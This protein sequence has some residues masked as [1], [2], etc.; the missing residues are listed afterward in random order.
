MIRRALPAALLLLLVGCEGGRAFKSSRTIAEW[1]PS[2]PVTNAAADPEGDSFRATPP[3][4]VAS[5]PR[6]ESLPTEARLSNGIRVV[7][8]ERHDF[9]SIAAV[10]VLDRGATAGAPGVAALYSEAM[11]RSSS[12]YTANEAWQ[13]FQFVGASVANQTWRDGIALQ[14]SALSPLFVSALTRAAPMFT[15][16]AF[17]GDDIDEAR[18]HLAAER[19][20]RDED[21]SD[22]AY[23]AL[24][25]AIF[26]P[27]H[28][29]GTP[30]SGE[31]ARLGARVAGHS[32]D[33]T[34][35]VTNAAVKAFRS[36][37]LSSEHVGV[38][39]VGDFKPDAMRRILE[40]ALG[41]IPKQPGASSSPAASSLAVAPK[42][43]HRVIVIDRPGAAQSNVAIG[44]PGVRSS[45]PDLVTL[46]V[47]AG[48]TAGDLSTRLNLTVRKELGASYGVQ[49]VAAGLRDAGIV[50]IATAID[51]PKT[52]DALRGLFKD[53]ER[54]RAEPLTPGE[55]AAA[56]LRSYANLERGSSRGLAVYLGHAI[57]EGLPPAHAVMH[58]ARVDLVTADGV[59][60][61]AQRYLTPD[62]ARVVVVGDAARITEGLRSLALGDITVEKL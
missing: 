21:P 54:L 36:S 4:P 1:H 38:A 57:A 29:Y 60:A 19:A 27:P 15:S 22:V 59:R 58:N 7:M 12:E 18:T 35:T 26:P 23:D 56:K 13:Y 25:A 50:H 34:A 51:T 46:E 45:E 14:V 40:N 43:G 17:G 10:L 20:S 52:A 5:R 24:Y 61:A 44:W 53:I 41:K 62:E 55:L 3:P 33:Q 9:P 2:R 30:V 47:L 31:R 8:L 48:A 16:P 42:G 39:V 6:P 11:I 37:N 28:P 32:D 49:M